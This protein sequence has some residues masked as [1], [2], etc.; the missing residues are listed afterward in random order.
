MDDLDVMKYFVD[1][2]R[3]TKIFRD[4]FILRIKVSYKLLEYFNPDN[5]FPPEDLDPYYNYIL[6]S[7]LDP[8]N[9]EDIDLVRDFVKYAIGYDS[10][11]ILGSSSY[12]AESIYADTFKLIKHLKDKKDAKKIFDNDNKLLE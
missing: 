10:I 3:T 5:F 8:E 9:D 12:L 6:E 1:N 11:D 7:N 4:N 2:K